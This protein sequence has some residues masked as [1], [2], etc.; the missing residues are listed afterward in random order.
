MKKFMVLS[1]SMAKQKLTARSN[2]R[3]NLGLS[4]ARLNPKID[5]RQGCQ[6]STD[7]RQPIPSE[8]SIRQVQIIGPIF[9]IVVLIRNPSE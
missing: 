8:A 6:I 4:P 2:Q 5:D 3:Q 7:R 9:N 1:N